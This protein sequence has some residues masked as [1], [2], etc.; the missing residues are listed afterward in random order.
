MSVSAVSLEGQRLP[1]FPDREPW[2]APG[3][4]LGWVTDRLARLSEGPAPR[5]WWRAFWISLLGSALLVALL[6]YQISVGVGVWGNNRPVMWG[7]DI[8]NFVWWIG[9]GHAGTLISAMLFLL[10]QRWRT[11]VHRAAEAMTI[12]AVLCAAIYPAVHVG[13]VWFDWWLL[14]L[15]NSYG[16]VWP[17]FRSP[18]MWDLFALGT[19][20]IVSVLFCYTGLIPDLA[21]LRDRA[22]TKLGQWVYGLLAMGWTGSARQWSHYQKAYLLLAGLSTALVVS[23]HSIVALNFA[24][25]Q[26]PGW[27]TTLF[28]PYFVVGAIVSGLGM[29][30]T[31]LILLRRLAE[32]D[33]VIT[34]RHIDCLGKLTL[35]MCSLLG[36]AYGTELF[37]AWYSGNPFERFAV[38]HRAT[39]PCAGAYWG[40]I[41]CCLVVPQLLW[42]PK[43][44]RNPAMVWVIA[45]LINV[46]MWLER[47]VIVVGV[48]E[49]DFLPPNWSAYWPTW[50]DV[51]TYVGTF[52]LFMTC[53]LLFMRFLPLVPIFEVKTTLP[54]ADPQQPQGS[55]KLG[56]QTQCTPGT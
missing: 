13:R 3:C 26:L 50:A 51:G 9:I 24:A 34:L 2:I 31:L 8:I 22:R 15:P 6:A 11:A 54:Q 16:P 49:R 43:V 27:H 28:P 47:Y 4:D 42:W 33:D 56:G 32:L 35:A 52:G 38:L 7:W 55:P 53:F 23:V 21:V 17:Q 14:P 48:L 12:F 41:G 19:Y 18:L 46:G 40:M 5:W 36:Y 45:L 30:L 20:F 39:G 44:R 25:S 37:M 29:V 1:E 10:R